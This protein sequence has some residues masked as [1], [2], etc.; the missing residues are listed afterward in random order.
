MFSNDNI[1]TR[2]SIVSILQD[3]YMIQEKK[4][5]V[6]RSFQLFLHKKAMKND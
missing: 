2:D 5:R 6:A 4:K 1:Y 3:R